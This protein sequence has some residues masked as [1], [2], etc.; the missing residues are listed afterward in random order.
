VA[1]SHSSQDMFTAFVILFY[2]WF[3][4]CIRFSLV[5]SEVLSA[6]SKVTVYTVHGS[7]IALTN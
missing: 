2:S 5:A 1:V 3:K 7:S 4:R 6:V